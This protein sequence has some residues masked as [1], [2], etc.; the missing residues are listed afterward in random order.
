MV[1]SACSTLVPAVSLHASLG[2]ALEGLPSDARRVALDPY[3][4]GGPLTPGGRSEAAAALAI[5]PE[6]GWS[7]GERATLRAAGFDLLHLGDRVLRVE[8][9]AIVGGALLLS[10]LGAWRA[11][12]PV[13]G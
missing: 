10:A 13:A 2:A 4:A 3:E 1:A 7:D 8:A 9:A 5:G 6:R 11:H 12:R